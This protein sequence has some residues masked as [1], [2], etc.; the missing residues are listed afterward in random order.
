MDLFWKVG[1]EGAH[2]RAIV[3]AT[4]LNRFSL[5]KEFGGKE[6]LFEEALDRYLAA[7]QDAYDK[8]LE[9]KPYCFD[10]IR[11]YFSAIRYQPGYHGCFMINTLIEKHVVSDRAFQKAKAFS[12]NAEMM[13][14]KNL[15]GANS[16]GELAQDLPPG[17]LAK[18]LL[19]LDQGLA[20]YGIT[21]PINREKEQVVNLTLELIL[22][23]ND[24]RDQLLPKV[25]EEMGD[26]NPNAQSRTRKVARPYSNL[27]R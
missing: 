19:S 2:L 26:G 3:K 8:H 22:R 1:Y 6:G 12:R 20:I 10:N 25:T 14:L 24:G 7:A 21:R 15:E 11:S 18:L 9:R 4:G 27:P 23:T 13:F 16:R 5:Y 17:V